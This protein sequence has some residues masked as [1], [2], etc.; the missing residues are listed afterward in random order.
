[1]S[2]RRWF[3]GCALAFLTLMAG[4]TTLMVGS[5]SRSYKDEF[6]HW[7]V[8]LD[9]QSIVVV[10]AR[11]HYVFDLPEKLKLALQSYPFIKV[12]Q[13]E[14]HRVLANGSVTGD[15]L[16]SLGGTM[17]REEKK[18]ALVAG[19]Q[20]TSS[21]DSQE[22]YGVLAQGG[23]SGNRFLG[24][25]PPAGTCTGRYAKP[26]GMVRE[27]LQPA[28]RIASTAAV[29]FAIVVDVLLLPV[30]VGTSN[31]WRPDNE[32]NRSGISVSCSVSD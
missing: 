12:F 25:P 21:A 23:L 16:I 20:R 13:F 26:R 28:E 22:G 18:A 19:F 31:H 2:L 29:P 30:Y 4:C 3:L 7:Y 5:G 27:D 11:Y 14:I 6:Q 17:P 8:S 1:M 9:G 10:G 15:Y 32:R 24:P